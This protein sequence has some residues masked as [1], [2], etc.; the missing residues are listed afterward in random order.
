MA[1]HLVDQVYQE[2]IKEETELIKVVRQVYPDLFKDLEDFNTFA[3]S[4]IPVK[5]HDI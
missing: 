1:E 2:I 5:I 3:V 4:S